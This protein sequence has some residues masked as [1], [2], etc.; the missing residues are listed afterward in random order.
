MAA[1]RYF[2]PYKLYIF[3]PYMSHNGAL[4]VTILG[5]TNLLPDIDTSFVTEVIE[6]VDSYLIRSLKI[7][8]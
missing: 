6:L 8:P 5:K 1:M 2:L 7:V 4:W 3:L